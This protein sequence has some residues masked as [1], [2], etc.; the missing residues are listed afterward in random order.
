MPKTVIFALIILILG[1]DFYFLFIQPKLLEKPMIEKV[2]TTLESSKETEGKIFIITLYDNYQTDPRLKTGWGFSCLI[3]MNGKRILFDTGADSETLL[4]NMGKMEINPKE[5]DFVF[6]SH[7]H[8]DHTGGL[9]GLLAIK[10]DLKVYKPESF[11]APEKII[12][13]VWTTGP[14][15]TWIKEQS[16]VINSEKGLIIITGCAHPGVVNIIEKAK[17][18]FPEK[19]VFL[20]LGGFHLSEASD[21]ELK[22]IIS[23]FKKL[24]VQKVAPCH[25][26]GDRCRELFKEEYKENFIENG[27]GQIIK[28]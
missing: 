21:P 8:G 15:G 27:V 26:S 11:S 5:I 28:I 18:M 20:V 23:D 25:C 6:I 1:L 12:D 16:L 10:P 4:S 24:G 14:L 3:K 17:E 2:K 19:R 22:S 13:G 7:L 9:S